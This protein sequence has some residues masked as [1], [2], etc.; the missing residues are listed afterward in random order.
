MVDFWFLCPFLGGFLSAR[1]DSRASMDYSVVLGDYPF[2]DLEDLVA[3]R[4]FK[5]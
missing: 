2:S 4:S 5:G 1:S 3:F